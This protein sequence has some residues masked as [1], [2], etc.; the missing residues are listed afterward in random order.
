MCVVVFVCLLLPVPVRFIYMCCLSV[1]FVCY[2]CFLYY[3]SLLCVFLVVCT[4]YFGRAVCLFV[5]FDL[6]LNDPVLLCCLP[7]A[8]NAFVCLCVC[9]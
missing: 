8:P 4:V 1:V 9:V 2:Y 6:C 7:G 3:S 5:C